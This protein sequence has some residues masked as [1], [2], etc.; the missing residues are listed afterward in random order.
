MTTND[1][2]D[3]DLRAVANE[4]GPQYAIL[5]CPPITL[6]WFSSDE[7]AAITRDVEGGVRVDTASSLSRETRMEIATA[8]VATILDEPK[9]GSDR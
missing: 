5:H 7:T 8:L 9:Q 3:N 1:L 4:L 2:T 6:P